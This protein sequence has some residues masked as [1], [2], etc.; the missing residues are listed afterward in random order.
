MER[1]EGRC[2]C[3]AVRF[4]VE[5]A[6][7]R[8]IRCNC[9]IC[10]RKGMLYHRVAPER[11]TLLAGADTV[12]LY[13]FGDKVA[14]HFFCPLCGIHT[15]SNPKAAPTMV[16]VNVNC[17]EVPDAVLAAMTIVP[18]NGRDDWAAAA[19]VVNAALA[20]G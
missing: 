12:R 3:G 2:H 17:L 10:Q 6:L 13:Q 19:S 18:F 1:Y 11:F 16:S 20:C 15:F 7:D 4:A 14:K 9:S 8:A 5:T